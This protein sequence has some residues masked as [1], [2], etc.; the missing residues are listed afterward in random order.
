MTQAPM[1]KNNKILCI[2]MDEDFVLVKNARLECIT[3]KKDNYDNEMSYFKIKD[4]V[5]EQKNEKI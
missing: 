1:S 5:I 4:K 3:T 2:L